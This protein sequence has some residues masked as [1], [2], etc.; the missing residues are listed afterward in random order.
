MTTL[1]YTS[2]SSTTS[3]PSTGSAPVMRARPVL[4]TTID[5]SA[6]RRSLELEWQLVLDGVTAKQESLRDGTATDAT[7]AL[8]QLQ[9]EELRSLDV[10]LLRHETGVCDVCSSCG[11]QIDDKR[12]TVLPTAVRCDS[13]AQR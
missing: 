8:L 6:L 4:H 7:E 3:T 12:L 2:S 10:A 9:L 1:P 5:P 11:H 13:C